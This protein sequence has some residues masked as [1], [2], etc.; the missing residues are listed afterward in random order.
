MPPQCPITPFLHETELFHSGKGRAKVLH[1]VLRMA[2][3]YRC[4][5]A[6][7]QESPRF[8]GT[9][10]LLDYFYWVDQMFEHVHSQNHVEARLWQGRIF[11]IHKARREPA[12]LEAPPREIKQR[13]G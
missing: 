4:V 1:N 8:H 10:K 13:S 2:R 11:Q 9:P 7:K 12:L 6:R 3:V 5:N